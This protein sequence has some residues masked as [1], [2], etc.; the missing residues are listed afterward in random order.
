MIS[1]EL[2]DFREFFEPGVGHRDIAGIGLDGA[3][4]II[5]RLRRRRPGQ[6]VEERRFAGRWANQRCRI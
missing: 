1:L 3:K 5:R 4:G 2:G 6:R